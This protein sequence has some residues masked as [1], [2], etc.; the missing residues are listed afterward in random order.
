M[1]LREGL[2]DL[3]LSGNIPFSELLASVENEKSEE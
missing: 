3:S 2:D 1:V